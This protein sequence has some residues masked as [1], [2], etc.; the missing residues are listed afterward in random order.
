[1]S[2]E[3]KEPMT[4]SLFE[5][6]VNDTYFVKSGKILLNMS[7]SKIADAFPKTAD[8]IKIA[9]AGGS[10]RSLFMKQAPTDLD[11]F[12]LT[13]RQ[14]ALSFFKSVKEVLVNQYP[15]VTFDKI[16]EITLTV[17]NTGVVSSYQKKF[18]RFNIPPLP[19]RNETPIQLL[20][21]SH[22]IQGLEVYPTSSRELIN[23][24]DIVPACF[25]AEATK[26]PNNV[27][28]FTGISAHA[29]LL[30]TLVNKE[31]VPNIVKGRLV[32]P[33]MSL[34][35]FYKYTKEYGFTVSKE[36]MPIFSTLMS[37]PTNVSI[38]YDTVIGEDAS[39]CSDLE[40]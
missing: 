33:I 37:I 30:E 17:E 31:L 40:F 15:K 3:S 6:N 34:E 14:T 4:T 18:I 38:H 20:Q 16:A 13:D 21:F 25:S 5:S 2:V 27:F 28:E 35:R 32:E 10:F 39:E 7:L 24:F 12:L 36:N 11:L 9:I 29:M 19:G 8:P 26:Y 23:M 1:M 22:N